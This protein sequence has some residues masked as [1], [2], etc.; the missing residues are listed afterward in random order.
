MQTHEN[1]SLIIFYAKPDL[2]FDRLVNTFSFYR[3]FKILKIF[4]KKNWLNSKY[5]F[6]SYVKKYLPNLKEKFYILNII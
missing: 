4:V 6:E 2:K 1:I 3:P 5:N